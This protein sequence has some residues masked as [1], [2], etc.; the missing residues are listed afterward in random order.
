MATIE[1]I[2]RDITRQVRLLSR[3]RKNEQ[4]QPDA[5]RGR[6]QSEAQR[7]R[8]YLSMELQ[9]EAREH[10]PIEELHSTASKETSEPFNVRLMR[11]LLDWYKNDHMSW[12][13]NL[14]CDSCGNTA[15]VSAG[16]GQPTQED[17]RFGAGRVELFSCPTCASVSRFPRYNS[18]SKL[19]QTR[20]GRCG[21]WANLFTLYSITMRFETRYVMDYTDHVWCE[22]FSEEWNRWVHVDPSEGGGSLD[23]PLMY[24]QGWKKQLIYVFAIGEYEVVDVFRRYTRDVPGML[25]RRKLA[26]ETEIQTWTNQITA[27]LQQSVS[28]SL[29]ISLLARSAQEFTELMNPVA[30]PLGDSEK[31]GRQSGS[32]EW[33]LARGETDTSALTA[34]PVPT[35]NESQKI[36][37]LKTAPFQYLGSAKSIAS[38]ATSYPIIQLTPARNDQLGAVWTKLSIT[39]LSSTAKLV[40]DFK[41]RAG[42]P[43]GG[44]ADGFAIVLQ[45]AGGTAIGN[46]GGGLGYAGIPH[47]IAIEFD[48]YASRDTCNDPDGNHVSI[49]TRAALPN[50]AHHKYS[51]GCSSR[52]PELARGKVLAVRVVWDLNSSGI[53]GGVNVYMSDEDLGESYSLVVSGDVDV[54]GVLDNGAGDWFI[55][56]TAATGGLNQIH[57][58]VSFDAYVL[59]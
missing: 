2:A 20:R 53:G 8:Q 23:Q 16:A 44:G 33:R 54:K 9:D 49:Q 27:T 4:Q 1:E 17:H 15:T 59:E 45:S 57:E 41:F 46:G 36:L 50:S 10:I 18:P 14:A 58:I 43:T 48:M 29:R 22:F 7:F 55:G 56:F 19:M 6:L 32:V 13:N 39:N 5:I 28:P 3:Q 24:E 47:S 40:T 38:S 31:S 51:R 37:S 42:S 25:F 11:A 34:T 30:R 35:V 26:R 52:V 12:V 21:E